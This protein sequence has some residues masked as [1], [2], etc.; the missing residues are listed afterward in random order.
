MTSPLD[1]PAARP[2]YPRPGAGRLLVIEDDANLARLFAAV[3]GEAGH[4]VTVAPTLASAQSHLAGGGW[5]LVLLDL[6]LPDG[7]GRQLLEQ[8]RSQPSTSTLPVFIVSAGIGPQVRAECTALGADAYFEKPVD[9]AALAQAVARRLERY[10][11]QQA[12]ARRDPLTGLPNRAAFLEACAAL[13]A[14]HPTDVPISVAVLDFD[15]FLW[16]RETWGRTYADGILR[17]A[18]VRL[19]VLLSQADCLARWD[20]SDF[21]ALFARKTPAEAGVA[22]QSALESLRDVNFRKGQSEPLV[23][24]YSA[25]VA[26]LEAGGD[27]NDALAQADRLCYIAKSSG[28]A[29]VVSEAVATSAPSR[30]I[31]LA[32]DDPSIITLVGRYL[33][34]DGFSVSAF[35]NGRTA[36]AAA[37]LSGASLL[38]TDI[39]MPELDGIGLIR[40]IRE[41]P[42]LRHLP[43]MVLSGLG[44]E[45]MIVRAIEAGADEYVLKPFSAREVAVRVRRLLRR[46]AVEGTMVLEEVV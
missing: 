8:L 21:V 45:N 6:L 23:L 5:D 32:E 15:H 14:G 20:G 19:S 27:V 18:G 9:S 43:I 30:R 39:E 44:D 34:H 4:A 37:P 40:G 17:R 38:I 35:P 28:R 26:G 13:R 46:P 31:L 22:L 16:V 25:G 41:H 2:H 11:Q 29:R 1:G 42:A 33:R 24:T 36:L 10:D 7:D 3:L 12:Q